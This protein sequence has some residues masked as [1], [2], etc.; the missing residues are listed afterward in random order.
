MLKCR[1]HDS[2]M[3][4][5]KIPLDFWLK[6][7]TVYHAWNKRVL[8]RMLVLTTNKVQ[9]DSWPQSLLMLRI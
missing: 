2:N 1:P 3:S 5:M 4:A 7:K 6:G 8:E 9:K